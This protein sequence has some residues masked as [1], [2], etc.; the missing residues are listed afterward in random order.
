MRQ[1]EDAPSSQHGMG[2]HCQCQQSKPGEHAPTRACSSKAT[3]HQIPKFSLLK[4]ETLAETL[5]GRSCGDLSDSTRCSKLSGLCLG[6]DLLIPWRQ[7]GTR[8]IQQ[9]LQTSLRDVSIAWGI[10]TM[11]RHALERNCEVPNPPEKETREL[12]RTL[13]VEA[14]AGFSGGAN[15]FR[16]NTSGC[17][18]LAGTCSFTMF[19]TCQSLSQG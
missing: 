15:S 18:F 1:K 12:N 9:R 11:Y 14:T 17:S 6:I 5:R 2:H 13:H 19:V 7:N 4:L 8:V 10:R 16:R 3:I